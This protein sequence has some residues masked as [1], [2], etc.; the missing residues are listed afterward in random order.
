MSDGKYGSFTA[1]IKCSDGTFNEYTIKPL[2]QNQIAQ[3]WRQVLPRRKKMV[4]KY[5]N[6]SGVEKERNTSNEFY[7]KINLAQLPRHLYNKLRPVYKNREL[8]HYHARDNIYNYIIHPTNVDDEIRE[9]ALFLNQNND[10]VANI[11]VDM[12]DHYR[13]C[14]Q[15]IIEA[16]VYGWVVFVCKHLFN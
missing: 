7:F 10:S 13:Q 11:T 1:N 14:Y 9:L 12:K 16:D 15:R 5:T 3:G 4:F 2:S 8:S 6:D